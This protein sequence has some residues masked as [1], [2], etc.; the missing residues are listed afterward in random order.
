MESKAVLSSG[1]GGSMATASENQ[2]L[3]FGTFEVDMKAGELRRNGN[4]VRLQEQPFQILAMLLERPGEVVSREELRGRLWPADTF[5]DFDHSLNAA[6]RRL[7]DALGDSA[8]NSRFVETVARRGYRLLVPVVDPGKAAAAPAIELLPGKIQSATSSSSSFLGSWWMAGIVSAAVLLGIGLLIGWSLGRRATPPVATATRQLTANPSKAP[9]ISAA[10]S[11]DGKLLAY[12]DQTGMYLRQVPTGETHP[13]WTPAHVKL[14]P[15]GWFPDGTR[16]V[17]VGSTGPKDAPSIWSASILG[18]GARKLADDGDEPAVSADGFQIAFLRGIPAASDLWVM[19]SDGSNPRRLV[20]AQGSFISSP[21]WSPDGRY[22]AFI[23]GQYHPGTHSVDTQIDSVN[24]A[25]GA[26]ETVLVRAGMN[27]G[28]AWTR[29]GRLIFAAAE[30]RPNPEDS[31]LWYLNLDSVSAKAVG[32]PIR[33]NRDAGVAHSVSATADGKRL[34]FFRSNYQPDVYVAEVDSRGD[35]RGPKVSTPQ[36]LTLDEREDFP[37]AWTPDNRSVIFVSNRD[38]QYHI[39]RQAVDQASAELL[40]GGPD[41][42]QI[43]RL[44]PDGR[45]LLYLVLPKIGDTSNRVRMMRV[46]IEGGPSQFVLEGDGINN[47][48]CAVAP[49]TLCIFSLTAANQVRF[50]RFDPVSGKSEEVPEWKRSHSDYYKFN[51]SLSPDGRTLAISTGSRDAPEMTLKSTID[52]AERRLPLQSWAGISSFDWA[53]D[54]QSIWVVAYTYPNTS[55]LVN[56]DTQGHARNV[57]EDSEM[58]IGWAIPSPDGRRLALWKG[59]GESN[60]WM[61]DGF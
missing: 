30:A 49:A 41:K 14:F 8:E 55:F 33:I 5:V 54:S 21:T 9:V 22:V 35:P 27:R 50:F 1:P 20:E 56:L 16:L 52:G 29:T 24:L 47:E 58:K 10:L 34:V 57:L 60:V 48:Q 45:T 32:T 18:G 2:R 28:L 51:W 26:R 6:I 19:Q 25:S 17:A 46:P 59:S 3:Q 37:Y 13:L 53:S 31:N 15:N 11:P 36:L 43:P 38:G 40:V 4:R 42:L 23:S 39:Y 61:I 12:A 7:R 44:A